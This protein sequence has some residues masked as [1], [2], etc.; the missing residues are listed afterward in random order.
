[1]AIREA[2]WRRSRTKKGE[3]PE[4]TATPNGERR[5]E[6]SKVMMPVIF[7]LSSLLPPKV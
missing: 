6:R 3:P 7:L 5:F 2:I 4:A 1:M